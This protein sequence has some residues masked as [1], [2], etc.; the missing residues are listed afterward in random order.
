M[1]CWRI[2]K[3]WF[4]A[5]ETFTTSEKTTSVNRFWHD[6]VINRPFYF[7]EVM[8]DL[9]TQGCQDSFFSWHFLVLLKV[10]QSRND[11]F[12]PTFLPKNQQ[13]NSIWL[14]WSCFGRNWRHQKD[15]S[16]LLTLR[17][18][19]RETMFCNKKKESKRNDYSFKL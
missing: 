9:P 8:L 1:Y 11:F 18:L 14:L 15:I 16:K 17:N 5:H 13:T 7:A 2:T 12:K 6:L 10:S 3:T 19:F 4:Q